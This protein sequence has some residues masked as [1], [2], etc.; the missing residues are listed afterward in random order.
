MPAVPAVVVMAMPAV[1]VVV[2]VPAVMVVAVPAVV[3]MAVPRLLHHPA[4]PVD[5]GARRQQGRR[6]CRRQC[7]G[8][9]DEDGGEGKP[10]EHGS[11]PLLEID[12][13]RIGSVFPS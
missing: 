5:G 2:A 3:A 11:L 12:C 6:G 7:G 9:C 13:D 1:V 8:G 10:A 4:G